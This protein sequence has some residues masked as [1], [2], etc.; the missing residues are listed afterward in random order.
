MRLLSKKKATKKTAV[1]NLEKNC[2]I[3]S[4]ASMFRS[5][6]NSRTAN[7][8]INGCVSKLWKLSTK[9]GF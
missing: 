6:S 2:G 1:L 4:T 3:L 9:G 8:D 7:S 5:Q